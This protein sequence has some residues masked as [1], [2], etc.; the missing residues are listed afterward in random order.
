LTASI[1][2]ARIFIEARCFLRAYREQVP[3]IFFVIL[4]QAQR[5]PGIS[6]IPRSS[7]NMTIGKTKHNKLLPALPHQWLR[8]ESL[9]KRV[10]FYVHIVQ[11]PYV[12]FVILRQAQRVPGISWIPRSSRGMTS[13]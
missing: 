8:R 11:V 5:V 7:P 4:R 13:K 3:Y 12:F 10:A 1:A 9:L 2:A 6:W